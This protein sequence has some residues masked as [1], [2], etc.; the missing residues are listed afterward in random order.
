MLCVP[1]AAVKLPAKPTLLPWRFLPTE[2]EPGCPGL[3]V[4]EV[5]A[6]NPEVEEGACCWDTFC[7]S[8]A[9]CL[10]STPGDLG[11]LLPKGAVVHTQKHQGSQGQICS[12]ASGGG[13]WMFYPFQD[14]YRGGGQLLFNLLASCLL[15]Y[16][17]S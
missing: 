10:G 2:G 11:G 7:S 4:A 16:L 1:L 12:G 5:V 3:E 8:A 13:R 15:S 9:S 6:G 14:P 17:I